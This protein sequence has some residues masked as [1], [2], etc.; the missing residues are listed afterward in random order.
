MKII[1]IPTIIVV[2]LVLMSH[3]ASAQPTFQVWSPDWDFKGDYEG[4]Q[5]TWFINEGSS[6]E[7][8]AVGSYHPEI[9]LLNVTLLVS[10]PD[11]ETGTITIT[12]L[13]SGLDDP[14]PIGFYTDTS[15]LPDP[16][17]NNH[18][19]LKDGVSDFLIYDIDPFENAGDP[20]FDYN[21][22]SPGDPTPTGSTGQINKYMVAVDGFS[23]VHIDLY[24]EA[25][26]KV[27][28]SYWWEMNPASH[29]VTWIPAPGAFLLG[30]IGVCLV[31]WLRRRRAL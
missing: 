15:F 4:D 31:G 25:T 14:D 23:W 10:V 12:S 7:L 6:F 16:T 22:D 2:L 21:A 13:E 19:P 26:K 9:E 11:G 27:D 20:I 18:Y 29:D 17:M 8:W 28:G 1:K 3:T 5:D 30:G 24:G